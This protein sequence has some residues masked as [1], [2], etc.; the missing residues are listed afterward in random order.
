M[1]DTM[2]GA[3]CTHLKVSYRTKIKDNGLIEGWWSCDSCFVN[4]CT[5]AVLQAAEA[6]VNGLQNMLEGRD[7]LC[8]LIKADK[9]QAERDLAAAK[10]EIDSLR[11]ALDGE[12][13]NEDFK[14]EAAEMSRFAETCMA[15]RDALRERVRTGE[16]IVRAI[17]SNPVMYL[18]SMSPNREALQKWL[19][20]EPKGTP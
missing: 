4:F 7:A 17:L 9:E 5:I 16:A 19:A 14:R 3:A 11:A 10:V 8:T 2:Q 18:S 13:C 1:S 15:E 20:A 12:P 6:R